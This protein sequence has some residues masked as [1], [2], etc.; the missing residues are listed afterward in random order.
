MSKATATAAQEDFYRALKKSMETVATLR[1][2]RAPLTVAME[3]TSI[4][5][6]LDREPTCRVPQ[7][8]TLT[9][10]KLKVSVGA[11]SDFQAVLM[12]IRRLS[13]LSE[14]EVGEIVCLDHVKLSN[15]HNKAFSCKG[16]QSFWTRA[17]KTPPP[18]R[19]TEASLKEA[20][21]ERPVAI[22]MDPTKAPDKVDGYLR[23]SLDE[24]YVCLLLRE[25]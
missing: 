6:P 3:R 5:E 21:N 19:F 11:H 14:A 22:F 9:P 13:R 2:S 20:L 7:R 18:V 24:P 23:V 12:L 4:E 16:L 25:G 15:G 17:G 1:K 10:S 8:R